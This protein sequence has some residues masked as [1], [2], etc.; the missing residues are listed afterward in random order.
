MAA[1]SW[2]ASPTSSDVTSTAIGG[3]P[4]AV[5]AR[6]IVIVGG[7]TAG[8]IA[9]AMLARFV[10]RATRI[11]LVESD[12]IGAVGVGEATIPQIRFLTGGLGL[13]EDRLLAATGGTFKLGIEFVDW[14]RPGHCYLHAFGA[15]G[16]ALGV[17]PFHHY[18]LRG[19]AAGVAKPLDA[20]VPTAVA[21]RAGRFDRTPTL[22]YAYHF[23]A[24]LLAGFLRQG[25][26]AAGVERTEGRVVAVERDGATGDVSGVRLDDGRVVSGDLFL[27]C[28]GFRALLLGEALGVGYED[29]SRWL[30]CDRAMA[31]ACE[32][33]GDP[34][35]YTRATARPVGWQWRIPLQHRVGNGLVYASA[36]LSDDEAAA[37]LLG[38]LDGAALGDPRALRFTTGKRRRFWERNVVGVGLASGFMEPLEST[39]IHMVQSAVARLLELFPTGRDD[40]AARDAYNRLTDVEYDRIRDF[41]ILHYH[42]NERPGAF[43]ERCRATPIPDTLAEKIRQFRAG[44]RVVREGDEL[45][46]EPGWVQV[47]TGQGIAPTRWSPL[48]EQLSPDQLAAFLGNIRGGIADQVAALPTHADFVARHC[49]AKQEKQ[50][51]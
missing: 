20:Y 43:W 14:W 8:W 48:A 3:A 19:R 1:A 50:D 25:A 34:L 5:D 44:G 32:S 49:A 33:T 30:P 36:D 24:T 23:D 29:W 45:F 6:T 4:V 17:V 46:T 7:G 16:R 26:E 13:D 38:E 10:P 41:L 39:S 11:R 31:V 21:A 35:P 40:D 2:P 12:A 9:A 28:S 42:A 22:P 27:D 18:W 37:R 15:L 47:M 51:A